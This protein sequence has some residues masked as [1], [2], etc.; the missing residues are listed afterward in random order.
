VHRVKRTIFEDAHEDFRH[1]VRAFLLK[2]GLPHREAWEEA[3]LVDREFWRRAAAQSMVAF[4]A[5][6]EFGGLGL[7]DFRLNAVIDE[8][9][10]YTGVVGD[11]F[12][13]TNDIALPY[14]TDLTDEDQKARWL[15]AITRGDSVP[16]IAMTEPGAGSDLRGIAAVAIPDGDDYVLNGSKT[17]VTNGI[18][19]DLILVAAHVG[20]DKRGM[21]LF[22]VEPEMPGFSRG[23]K[24][25]KLGR[26]AQDTAELFFEDVVVP[27]RNLIGNPG[28]GL[29]YLMRNLPQE[30]L[31]MAVIAVAAA[32]HAL[33]L[34]KDYVR[35][36]NAF[37]GPIGSLQTVRFTLAEL[38]TEIAVARVYVDRCL[39]AH[40]RAELTPV[41]AAA[42]KLWTC[43]LQ[44]RA[45]DTCLQLH[46]GYGYMEEYEIARMWRDARVTRIYGGTSEIMK[47]IVGR[48][49]ELDRSSSG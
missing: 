12:N 32:E 44:G 6:E 46:G 25:T 16:A 8:E 17:F 35:D 23:R 26:R 31:S 45:M 42:A 41:E 9:V 48:S 27:A 1:S 33:D 40:V 13:L 19:A 43:E 7:D 36:R 22:A 4:A 5:P 3:G 18:Q 38:A 11:N 2:E 34:T 20:M 28:E 21:G 14:L 10:A 15:P 30:R 47:E 49:L 24:L 39:E 29:R 37:G